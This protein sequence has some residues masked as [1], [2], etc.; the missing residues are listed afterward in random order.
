MASAA[1]ITERSAPPIRTYVDFPKPAAVT[2]WIE[3]GQVVAGHETNGLALPA[4]V[5]ATLG[6]SGPPEYVVVG[7]ERYSDGRWYLEFAVTDA[8]I[9]A[10][11]PLCQD[12]G[13]IGDQ[14]GMVTFEDPETGKARK[15]RCPSDQRV[16]RRR[17]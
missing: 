15:I 17:R 9:Q 16:A 5:M 11:K 4:R 1:P 3:D 6:R 2:D 7:E 14:H 13:G 12:C 8:W 10:N